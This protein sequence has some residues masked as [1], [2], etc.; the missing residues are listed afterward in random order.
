MGFKTLMKRQ[1]RMIPSKTVRFGKLGRITLSLD[2]RRKVTKK[3]LELQIDEDYNKFALKPSDDSLRG[4]ALRDMLIQ[5]GALRKIGVE[6]EFKA[7]FTEG[8]II[9]DDFPITEDLKALEFW[10]DSLREEFHG[11]GA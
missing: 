6:G 2:L 3:Y 9:I 4:F 7:R 10:E 5:V 1:C 8:K 11:G